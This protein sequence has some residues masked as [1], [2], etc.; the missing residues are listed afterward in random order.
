MNEALAPRAT[1]LRLSVAYAALFAVFGLGQP[2]LPMWW[3][4]RGLGPVELGWLTAATMVA[5]LLA[6][7]PIGNLADRTGRP[8]LIAA[9]LLAAV[10]L[11][12]FAMIGAEGLALILALAALNGVLTPPALA[13]LDA[14]ALKRCA[15]AALVYGRV[16]VWGS[17]AFLAA[18]LGGGLLLEVAPIAVIMPVVVGLFAITAVTFLAIPRP[19]RG[20]RPPLASLWQHGLAV[21]SAPGMGWIHLAS[22]LIQNAHAGYYLFAALHWRD[23]GLS[24]TTIGLL[25]SGA[26]VV[27]IA[28]MTWAGPIFRL[29]SPA[30][31]LVLAGAVG[32]ARWAGTAVTVDPWNLAALQS[33]HAVT[34]AGAHLAALRLVADRAPTGLAATAQG[35]Y[36]ALP[37]GLGAA[38]AFVASGWLWRETGAMTFMAMAA[39]AGAG[40]LAALPLIRGSK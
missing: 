4:A 32:I 22:G 7:G 13:L 5:K 12:H 3:S 10:T 25:W 30:A 6:T 31:M 18:S 16:R 34:F 38:A 40:G 23:A 24:P 36:A 37:M 2:Y 8:D 28:L 26:V 19:D 33:L 17:V 15:S 20:D 1:A 21:L 35:L 14:V 39:L 11:V 9:G 29:V 27:E